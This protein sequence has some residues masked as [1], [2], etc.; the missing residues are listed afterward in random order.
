MKVFI[1]SKNRADTMTTHN[2]FPDSMVVLHNNEQRLAYM[3]AGVPKDRIVVSDTKDDAYGLTR[4]REWV[5]QYMAEKDEWFL[6]ADDNVKSITCVHPSMYNDSE[7][8]VKTP[9]RGGR[10]SWREIYN[11]DISGAEFLQHFAWADTVLADTIGAKMVGYSL[12]DNYFFR[13][14]KYRQVGYVVGK[15]YLLKN[16]VGITWDHTITMEDFRN[17]AH[18]LL[19]YGRVLINNFIYPVRQHYMKGGMGTK[20][21]RRSYRAQD[22]RRLMLQYPGLFTRKKPKPDVPDDL[23]LRLTTIEQVHRWRQEM[24]R[25]TRSGGS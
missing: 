3:K 4:Q 20:E 1:P 13:G 6:F 14:K 7:L 25:R 24:I 16:D 21:E 2:V 15:M 9:C 22:V 18:H 23:S 8:E 17:T 12:T 5:C 19:W 11:Y 10:E